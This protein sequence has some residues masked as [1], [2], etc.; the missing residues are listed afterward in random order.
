MYGLAPICLALSNV[1]GPL[2]DP[3]G[4]AGVVA[5]FGKAAVSGETATVFGDGEATR[6]YVYVDDVVD[7]FVR[8]GNAEPWLTGVFNIGTGRQ[9]SVNELHRLIAAAAGG[10]PP[11][12]YTAARTGEVRAIA[13][14]ST[15]ARNDLGWSPAVDIAEGVRR[16]VEWVRTTVT[17]DPVS[18]RAV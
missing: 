8:A 12:R 16:T 17:S 1:Y 18:Q 5:I 9:T 2:Q 11:P 14:N 3:H 15:R 10:A 4:E 13:L 6:D 7:A